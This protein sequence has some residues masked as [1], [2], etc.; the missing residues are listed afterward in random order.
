MFIMCLRKVTSTWS[1]L[2]NMAYYDRILVESTTGL[3]QENYDK[4]ISSKLQMTKSLS[5]KCRNLL[6]CT[7]TK[8][9]DFPGAFWFIKPTEMIVCRV[10]INI[11]ICLLSS[12]YLPPHPA[13]HWQVYPL[14]WSTQLPPLRQGWLAHSSI[15]DNQSKSTDQ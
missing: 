12:Q 9:V 4:P 1:R 10:K 15:S 5:N 6:T 13:V 7:F 11:S 14:T 3:N 2:G 8:I